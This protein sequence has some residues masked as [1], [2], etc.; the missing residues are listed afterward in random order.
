MLCSKNYGCALLI[1][2]IITFC[3]YGVDKKKAIKGKRRIS[4]KCLF[5]FGIFG[6]AIGA[7][8]GMVTFSHKTKHFYF[9]II[10]VF[11]LIIQI[12]ILLLL[13]Y[14]EMKFL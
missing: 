11:M 13:I 7:I 12:A 9:W 8:L 5:S 4:E 3:L 6:G 2:S 14:L 10:N 1:I